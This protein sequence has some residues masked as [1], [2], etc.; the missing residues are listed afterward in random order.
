MNIL[1]INGGFRQGYQD[2]S[3]VLVRGGEVIA[4]VEEERLSRVKHSAGRLPYLSV[5]EVLRIGGLS[6]NDIDAVAFHGS[7]WGS[8]IDQKVRDYFLHHFGYAPPLQK[9]HHHNCHATSA[10]YASGY[11]SALILTIDGS[12]DGV[13]LQVT[14]GQNGNI[15]ELARMNRPNSLGIFYSLFTQYCG[16]VK[17]CDE[18]KL[19]G[20]ASYGNRHAF[21]FG[22]LVDFKD[23]QLWLNKR[24]VN[25]V[26]PKAPALHRDEMNFSKAF[27][28][29]MGS[30]RRLPTSTI[31]EY[32]K[33]VAASGIKPFRRG[34][35]EHAAPLCRPHGSKETLLGRWCGTQLCTQ[36]A[37]N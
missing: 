5:L 25:C 24:Y 26:P 1:G 36:P 33:D 4:A 30:P 15:N 18:Y 27:L 23:G 12:G 11:N 22:W 13:S 21:D 20:L 6:I 37:Y 19:M 17:D 35:A 7:T 2:V 9:Y 3:A 14:T 34:S 32:Y 8:E 29:R 28:Q 16:F 31:S 10:Y